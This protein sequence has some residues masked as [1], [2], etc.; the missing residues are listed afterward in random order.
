M[1]LVNSFGLIKYVLTL[2][3]QGSPGKENLFV[4]DPW[5][6]QALEIGC[7]STAALSGIEAGS[8][9]STPIYLL[10]LFPPCMS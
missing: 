3:G 10:F 8:L 4:V 9:S 5:R 7:R 2:Q 1:D 6:I